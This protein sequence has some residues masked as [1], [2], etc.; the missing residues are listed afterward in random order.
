MA[1]SQM[2]VTADWRLVLGHPLPA[3]WRPFP[4]EWRIFLREIEIFVKLAFL[5][6]NSNPIQTNLYSYFFKEY[7]KFQLAVD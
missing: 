1:D 5:F 7:M 2:A 3:K 4:A 6:T